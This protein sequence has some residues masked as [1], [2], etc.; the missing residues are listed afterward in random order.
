MRVLINGRI[1]DSAQTNICIEMTETERQ[2]IASMSSCSD[3]SEK[4]YYGQYGKDTPQ[5]RFEEDHAVFD[6]HAGEYGWRPMS[7]APR[8]L[9]MDGV[10]LLLLNDD[11][12]VDAWFDSDDCVWICADDHRTVEVVHYPD[13][14]YDDGEA[15]AWMYR[16]VLPDGVIPSLWKQGYQALDNQAE[17]QYPHDYSRSVEDQAGEIANA[18]G[19]EGFDENN[20][21]HLEAVMVGVTEWRTDNPETSS[22]GVPFESKADE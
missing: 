4:R 20:I 2:H 13:G 9:N 11:T 15:I 12:V 6:A 22:E 1:F 18:A 8:N 19:L 3:L 21:A 7:E 5:T 14:R 17:N 16:E 10:V